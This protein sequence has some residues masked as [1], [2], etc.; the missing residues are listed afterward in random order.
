MGSLMD[1]VTVETQMG[2]MLLISCVSLRPQLMHFIVIVI[3]SLEYSM[4]RSDQNRMS[5][6]CS[7]LF[8]KEPGCLDLKMQVC[9]VFSNFSHLKSDHVIMDLD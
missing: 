2:R 6:L 7:S 4:A 5:A 8:F 9:L 1:L 3:V